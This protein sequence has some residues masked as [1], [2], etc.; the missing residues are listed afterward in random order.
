[1]FLKKKMRITNIIFY[2]VPGWNNY[3]IT[4]FYN[5]K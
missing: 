3:S 5:E 1:L 2:K 4:I